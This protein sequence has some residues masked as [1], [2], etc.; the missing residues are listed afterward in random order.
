[1][2]TDNF[3]KAARAEA[4][5]RYIEND[6]DYPDRETAIART[7][8]FADGAEW[9]RARLT[10]PEPT[11]AEVEAARLALHQALAPDW[12]VIANVLGADQREY[13][14]LLADQ[15]SRAALSAAR[16]VHP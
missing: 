10:A 11:N 9:A 8:A 2:T 7:A 12:M 15:L 13:D 3:A 5:W 16:E 14:A 4:E 6:P 1:M